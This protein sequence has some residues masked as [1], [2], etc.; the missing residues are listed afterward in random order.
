M[1]SASNRV[2]RSVITV[3]ASIAI[4]F[5]VRR[6]FGRLDIAWD[7]ITYHLPF[8][9]RRVGLCDEHC[10]ILSAYF[11][12]IYRSFPPLAD[13]I[14][15][16][17]WKVTGRPEATNLASLSAL[18]LL[19]AYLRRFWLIHWGLAVV[20]MLAIPMVQ[21]HATSSYIDLMTNVAATIAVL[22]LLMI[23]LHPE[24]VN[25]KLQIVAVLS[26]IFLGNSKTQM[27]PVAALL[28]ALFLLLEN[29]Y[30]Q[31]EQRGI[32]RIDR[33]HWIGLAAGV[34]LALLILA[35]P[36]R[37]L[38]LFGNPVYPVSLSIMGIHLPGTYTYPGPVSISDYYRDVPGPLRWLLSIMEFSA[39]DSRYTPWNID[40]ASVPQ[41]IPSFRM[42]GYFVAYVLATVALLVFGAGRLPAA[43][44]RRILVSVGLLTAVV[45]CLPASHELRYYM[46]WMMVMVAL[47][48]YMYFSPSCPEFR[49]RDTLAKLTLGVIVACSLSVVSL[50][51][52]RYFTATGSAEQF[53]IQ[54]GIRNTINTVVRDGDVVCV[55]QGKGPFVAL[56]ASI[57]HPG[58]RYS[59][60]VDGI[61][62]QCD[63]VL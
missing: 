48:L 37:N 28:G 53:V 63:K 30:V 43:F 5:L 59:V 35:S 29:I 56:Y 3:L 19:I 13:I 32:W 46:F 18:L 45:A 44:R 26:M 60:I 41:S 1:N 38:I 33:S 22:S 12:N 16:F 52:G 17:F 57:F 6:A 10:L 25:W 42:G 61:L 34:I 49:D 4:F 21:I 27:I 20:A 47:N 58:H 51:G 11:E 31:P 8:A 15:G 7:A 2:S 54:T 39:Y 62:A 40:Q 14:Q 50:S 55:R 9:A 23:V 24:R 36:L